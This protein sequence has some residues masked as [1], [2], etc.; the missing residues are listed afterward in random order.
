[1]EGGKETYYRVSKM[2]NEFVRRI[3]IIEEGSFP[4]GKFQSG[5]NQEC[6]SEDK[7][8][9]WYARRKCQ[10]DREGD[11]EGRHTPL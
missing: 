2:G 10:K 5:E 4:R 3:R 1:M 8:E 7:L 9:G 11:E 6:A